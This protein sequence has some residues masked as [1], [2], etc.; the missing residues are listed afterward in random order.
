[1]STD[2]K[3]I[4]LV[5]YVF[6][7]YA[8]GSINCSGYT[9]SK[10]EGKADPGTGNEGPEGEKRYNLLFLS[11]LDGGWVVNATPRPL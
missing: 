4:F 10:G 2:T 6:K 9:A 5:T 7:V 1:M 8:K 11:A 3:K